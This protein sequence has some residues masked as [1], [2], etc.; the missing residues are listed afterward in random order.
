MTM[1][2]YKMTEKLKAQ[3]AA[4]IT[5]SERADRY[6]V[7]FWEDI[8]IGPDEVPIKRLVGADVLNLDYLTVS[9]HDD[10]FT[11]T[12]MF[13][14]AGV[15]GKLCVRVECSSRSFASPRGLEEAVFTIVQGALRGL[16][17]ILLCWDD[18][19]N[20]STLRGTIDIR[21]PHP[22]TPTSGL[23]Q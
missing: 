15:D 8:T 4:A 23:G 19:A 11:W 9:T 5:S 10:V 1:N 16:N 3:V 7:P 18:G 6:R 2:L 14:V 13:R 21:C 17:A 22:E 12:A 20:A